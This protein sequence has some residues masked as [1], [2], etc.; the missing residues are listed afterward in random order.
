M[1]RAQ[2]READVPRCR[3]IGYP[4][5]E[6]A[7]GTATDMG[8]PEAEVTA[9]ACWQHAGQWHWSRQKPHDPPRAEQRRRG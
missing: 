7:V 9:Y 8:V 2:R 1:N 6:E 3:K 5:R 4:T